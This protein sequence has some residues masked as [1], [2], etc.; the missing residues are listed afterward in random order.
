MN[1][2]KHYKYK[3]R[4]KARRK[5]KDIDLKGLCEVCRKNPAQHRHHPDYSKPLQVQLLCT[6]CHGDIH[7]KYHSKEL[8]KKKKEW[9]NKSYSKHKEEINKRRREKYAKDR[10][11]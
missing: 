4:T 3:N 10:S 7:R 8:I 6:K 5:A 2:I 11:R 9:S 1:K